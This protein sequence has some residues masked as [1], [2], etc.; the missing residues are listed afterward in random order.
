MKQSGS[1]LFMLP[2]NHLRFEI[3]KSLARKYGLKIRLP[4]IFETKTNYETGPY[5]GMICNH[6]FIAPILLL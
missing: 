6:Y 3:L 2:N 5:V 4:K 1:A